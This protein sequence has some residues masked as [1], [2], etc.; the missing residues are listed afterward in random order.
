MIQ[1]S[2]TLQDVAA[3]AGLSLTTVSRAIN[4][5]GYVSKETV[6]KIRETC[7]ELGYPYS[8][9]RSNSLNEQSFIIGV[10]VPSLVHPFFG[11]FCQ[12][13]ERA[14]SRN[15]YSMLLYNTLEASTSS[16]KIISMLKQTGA[17]G[18][19]VAS[20]TFAREDLS[21]LNIPIVNFDTNSRYSSTVVSAN[22][23]LGGEMAARH[24]VERRCKN[25]LQII[26]DPYSNSDCEKRHQTFMNYV[27]RAGCTCVTARILNYQELILP[28]VSA[29]IYNI[30]KDYPNI[31]AV[32]A[33]DRV[34]VEVLNC[35]LQSGV[36]I[37]DKV[38]ILG[39]DGTYLAHLTKPTLTT[40]V[41]PIAELADCVVQQMV[42]LLHG[43]VIP[44]HIVIDHLQLLQGAS[45]KEFAD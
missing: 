14:L 10:V 3:K 39:Y 1:L 41:Q 2:P 33:A 9:R 6:H 30:L 38:Q 36:S 21:T 18:L 5:R 37:P 44:Q 34:A 19:I 29:I 45:T 4:G 20:H 17:D 8:K 16:D 31:D 25:I 12:T 28:D 35:Y 7:I 15:G 22:H 32:F 40:I 13:L 24:L 26:S 27:T 42:A 11:Q 23:S 43:E